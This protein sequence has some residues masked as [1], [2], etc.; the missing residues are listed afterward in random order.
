MLDWPTSAVKYQIDDADMLLTSLGVKYAVIE[1]KRPSTFDH[2][3]RA[4]AAALD[5]AWGYAERQQE[6]C[7]IASDTMLLDALGVVAGGLLPRLRVRLSTR[8]RQSRYG[9]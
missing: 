6:R 3:S 1:A 7:V 4:V 8:S 2:N 5:Q 9:G